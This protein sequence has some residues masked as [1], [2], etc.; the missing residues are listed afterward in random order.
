MAVVLR[1]RTKEQTLEPKLGVTLLELAQQ[2]KLDWAF[3]CTKGTCARCRCLIEEGAELLN[4]PTDAEWNRLGND[5]LKEGYRLGCQA[6][7]MHLGE[8][9]ASNKT[10]F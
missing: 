3:A 6:K 4:E 2:N 10:Y 8:L 5:E 9:K 1:G 7:M